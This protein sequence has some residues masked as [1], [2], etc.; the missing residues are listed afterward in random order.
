LIPSKAGNNLISIVY[1]TAM[2][3]IQP[4]TEDDKRTLRAD[5]RIFILLSLAFM[6]AVLLVLI[7]IPTAIVLLIG[8]D[9]DHGYFFRA[10][11][12]I[13][14]F[15][16]PLFYYLWKGFLKYLD[17]R[18]GKK[19]SITSNSFE[20]VK[21][22]K[23]S[24]KLRLHDSKR[25]FEVDEDIVPSIDPRKP[26]RLEIAPISKHLLFISHGDKNLLIRD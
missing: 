13:F 15:C 19:L 14:C 2:E 7:L 18:S 26:I 17:I 24:I 5:T 11:S 9:L 16:L 3:V 6:V 4:M 23:D 1:F 12:V 20:I 22:K 21:K 10:C 25:S 8:K